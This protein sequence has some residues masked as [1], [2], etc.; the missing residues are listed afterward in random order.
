M[1]VIAAEMPNAKVMLTYTSAIACSPASNPK[2]PPAAGSMALLAPFIDGLMDTGQTNEF[3]DGFEQS[4]Y[5]GTREQF[6]AAR[7][8]ITEQAAM[9]SADPQRYRQRMKVAFGIS[10]MSH[11]PDRLYDVMRYA[12]EYSDGYIWLYNVPWMDMP[13]DYEGVFREFWTNRPFA[14]PSYIFSAKHMAIRNSTPPGAP[15]PGGENWDIAFDYV[16]VA[17]HPD[18]GGWLNATGSVALRPRSS[19]P[20]ADGVYEVLFDLVHSNVKKHNA[21][22]P[23]GDRD[24]SFSY[25]LWLAEDAQGVLTYDEGSTDQFVRHFPQNADNTGPSD[26][27]GPVALI[28]FVAYGRGAPT[29]ATGYV[30]L[31]GVK[32]RDLVFEIRDDVKLNYGTVGIRAI[33]LVPVRLARA[34]TGL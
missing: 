26:Y 8:L 29:G 7:E 19:K 4:Y 28:D 34:Q 22:E 17:D 27:A 23:P 30:T 3:I 21:G 24:G 12:A 6:A 14:C 11:P 13:A 9:L 31:R 32:A 16:T 18:F 5:Y 33:R 15:G 1:E 10:A 20:I 2:M 25:R